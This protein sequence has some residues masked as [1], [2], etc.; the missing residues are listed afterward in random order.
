MT[1]T[2]TAITTIATARDVDI[3]R[4][5]IPIDCNQDSVLAVSI[6]S[7]LK[8]LM[9]AFPTIRSS[10]GVLQVV[11]FSVGVI[12]GVLSLTSAWWALDLAM[13]TA[14]KDFREDCREHLQAFNITSSKCRE[15]MARP[16][17]EPPTWRGYL[18]E[19]SRTITGRS[20]YLKMRDASLGMSNWT[21]SDGVRHPRS[22]LAS[23]AA[24]RPSVDVPFDELDG[25]F[26]P[27]AT[28]IHKQGD[29]ATM[30]SPAP[31]PEHITLFFPLSEALQEA[32]DD[33]LL[34][35]LINRP[36]DAW[37]NMTVTGTVER[38]MLY[39]IP[40]QWEDPEA[41]EDAVQAMPTGLQ[42]P[43]RQMCTY[44]TVLPSGSATTTLDSWRQLFA[45]IDLGAFLAMTFFLVVMG[46]E[47]FYGGFA[48][49]TRWKWQ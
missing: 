7:I 9:R 14:V 42:L 12:V 10:L 38:I 26:D 48:R 27:F 37:F 35:Y 19:T 34:L 22:H 5:V 11:K 1:T 25:F 8:R 20:H 16:L 36:C 30:Y 40:D 44:P 45:S 6:L 47:V 2:T 29:C 41:F 32:W 23:K 43:T 3:E 33:F 39:T 49:R 24:S 13:W 17:R 4:A 31:W 46:H 15:V 18:E 28:G 21:F